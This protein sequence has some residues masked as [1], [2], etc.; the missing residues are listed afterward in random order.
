MLLR[1]DTQPT[2]VALAGASVTRCGIVQTETNS[3]L[4]LQP[5]VDVQTFEPAR[6]CSE[7]CSDAPEIN[8]TS[9]SSPWPERLRR[10]AR[11]SSGEHDIRYS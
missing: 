10:S 5:T 8:V 3:H 6:I 7:S 2:S 1:F 4:L 9:T 11:Y